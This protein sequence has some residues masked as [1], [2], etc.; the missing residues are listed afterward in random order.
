MNEKYNRSPHTCTYIY[1]YIPLKSIYIPMISSASLTQALRLHISA[2]E[3][4]RE[5]IATTRPP[6]VVHQGREMGT[7][8]PGADVNWVKKADSSTSSTG[9]I[10]DLVMSWGKMMT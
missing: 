1:I 3:G 6:S 10:D 2:M 9:K 8:P 5:T 7:C 4:S